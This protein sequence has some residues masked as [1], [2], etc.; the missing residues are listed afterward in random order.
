[1][2]KTEVIHI[3]RAK[4]KGENIFKMKIIDKCLKCYIYKGGGTEFYKRNIIDLIE[5]CLKKM[6]SWINL[7]GQV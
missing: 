5:P 6:V 3:L 7:N 2:R 4:L 1:L